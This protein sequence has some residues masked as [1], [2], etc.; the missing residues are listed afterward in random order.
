[1]IVRHF[2]KSISAGHYITENEEF[3]PCTCEYGPHVFYRFYQDETL[4]FQLSP[5]EME[6]LYLSYKQAFKD[7]IEYELMLNN[8][9][10]KQ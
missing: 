5:D 3:L 8:S 7:N 1:M 4:V 10:N 6:A 2:D 9:K